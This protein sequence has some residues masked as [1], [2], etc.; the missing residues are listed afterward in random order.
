MPWVGIDCSGINHP[1]GYLQ[2]A[3]RLKYGWTTITIS[4]AE[5]KPQTRVPGHAGPLGDRA[6]AQA[7][8]P[9]V[10]RQHP[11]VRYREGPPVG[12]GGPLKPI[13]ASKNVVCRSAALAKNKRS[14]SP[15]EPQ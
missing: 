10:Q 5:L 4:R 12:F 8:L 13:A 2:N 14:I 3:H 9:G 7:R 15:N 11:L 1:L 6:G